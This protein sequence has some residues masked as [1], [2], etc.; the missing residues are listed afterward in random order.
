MLTPAG[1]TLAAVLEHMQVFPAVVIVS[2]L[3]CGT[4]RDAVA[5][6]VPQRSVTV[7][8][9]DHPT[10]PQ[11]ADITLV[12][13]AQLSG[14]ASLLAATRPAALAVID[15]HGGWRGSQCQHAVLDLLDAARPDALILL[16]EWADPTIIAAAIR[17]WANVQSGATG[18]VSEDL[19]AWLDDSQDGVS[20]QAMAAAAPALRT[21]LIIIRDW[22]PPLA[23]GRTQG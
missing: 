11:P 17:R 9:A 16:R 2:S 14:V 5:E 4:H 20:L 8:D 6:R 18:A 19:R 21:A 12:C 1:F 7:I 23:G 3:L 15:G 10:S 22:C 13:D